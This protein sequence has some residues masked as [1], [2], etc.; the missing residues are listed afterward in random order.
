MAAIITQIKRGSYSIIVSIFHIRRLI[1][2][3]I[4]AIRSA[5]SCS[6]VARRIII[7]SCISFFLL[8]ELVEEW[9][10]VLV[11][12]LVEELVGE[13]VLVVEELVGGLVSDMTWYRVRAS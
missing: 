11:P 12:E 1:K 10:V 2:T 13:E 5:I 7:R 3:V 6:L 9:L 4:S 8:P